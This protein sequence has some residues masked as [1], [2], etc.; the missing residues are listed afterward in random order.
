[1]RKG[2]NITEAELAAMDAIVTSSVLKG[3]SIHHVMA[4]NPDAFAVCEK[5]VYRYV[6]ARLLSAKRGDMP[7]MCM[8]KP[9]RKKSVEH[10]VDTKCR[11]GRTYADFLAFTTENPDLCVTEMDTVKGGIAGKCLLTLKHRKTGL[12]LAFLRDANTSLSAIE[13]IG[14]LWDATG[15]EA[16]LRAFP[17]LLTD[18]GTEFSNPSAI[19]MAP[20][21]TPRTKVFYCDACASYQKP[22]VEREHEE[23]RRIFPKGMS[24]D[25]FTQS[26]IAIA[27]SHVN[28]Y[29]RP[30][31]ADKSPYDL[32]A[33]A[34]GDT[35]LG[36]LGIRR[37]HANDI[38]LRT[39]LF[40]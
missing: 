36:E 20:D 5:T 38:V 3:Q 25:R 27:L 39:S 7:R 10:K 16:F 33:F 19:E 9:R 2:V 14:R 29:S 6:N 24:F 37:I 21:G 1:V 35:I 28:S 12:L 32:F 40:G 31:L 34:Y 22:A 23:L 15:A 13:G 4:N 30:T 8:L 18:N 26:D 17:V 11:V